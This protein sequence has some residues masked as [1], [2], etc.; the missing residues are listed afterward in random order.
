MHKCSSVT[1]SSDLKS[2]HRCK[3]VAKFKIDG[4]YYCATHVPIELKFNKQ[5]LDEST[6][7][8]LCA[9]CKHVGSFE[10]VNK[11]ICKP[12]YFERNDA[13]IRDKPNFA[14]QKLTSQA[15]HEE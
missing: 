8:P 15:H 5:V 12:C 13:G 7:T 10:G 4:R 1:V 2:E 6:L 9:E 14:P 11:K 3:N